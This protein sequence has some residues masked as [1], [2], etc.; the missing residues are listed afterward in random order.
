MD[1]ANILIDSGWVDPKTRPNDLERTI[2]SACE[3]MFEQPLENIRF[4]ELLLYIFDS[5]RRFNLQD[6]AFSNAS[7][8]NID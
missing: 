6:A 5:A 2:R 4:G 8:K 7:S 1:V 3:P